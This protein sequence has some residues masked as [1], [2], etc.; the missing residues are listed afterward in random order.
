MNTYN[1]IVTYADGTVE[2]EH[3]HDLTLMGIISKC[4]SY[5]SVE[6]FEVVKT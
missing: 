2:T 1:V 4:L 3:A 6:R 5:P